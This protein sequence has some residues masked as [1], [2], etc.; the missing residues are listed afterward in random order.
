MLERLLPALYRDPAA[1]PVRDHLGRRALRPLLDLVLTA[2][3]PPRNVVALVGLLGSSDAVPALARIASA[4]GRP[5]ANVLATAPSVVPASGAMLEARA[6]ALIALGRLGDPRSLPALEEAAT[7]GAPTLRAPAVWALGRLADPRVSP[8][9]ERALGDAHPDIQALACLGLGRHAN[10]RSVALLARLS[11]DAARPRELRL[12]ATLALGRAGGPQAAGE[13]LSILDRGDPELSRAAAMALA[14]TRDPRAVPALL[15]HALL[16]A[17]FALASP[18]APL[19]ALASWQDGTSP[20][21]EARSIGASDLSIPA[22]LEA[23]LETAPASDLTPVLRA[24]TKEID[25]ILSHA[26]GRGGSARRAALEALDARG[27][28]P[29]VGPLA[30]IDNGQLDPE[31]A[32]AAREIAWPLADG[33]ASALDD[34]DHRIRALALRVLAKL[35]D[36]R[37]TPARLAGAVADGTPALADA[38]VLSAQILVRTRPELAAPIAGAVAPLLS[39]GGPAVSWSCRLAAVQLLASLGPPGLPPLDRAI[40]DPNALVRAAALEAVDRAR[41]SRPRPPPG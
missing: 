1:D 18:E 9:L 11:A 20:P 40:N 21:D 17:E 15:A 6:A 31:A 37:L 23:L 29:A 19:A 12:A 7:A 33:I 4:S 41:P 35:G 26:L 24:H 32:A 30:P 10:A 27:D 3:V 28:G 38:A 13:L 16:P 8:L 25:A 22:M 5:P 2:D 39:A 34:P 14:W 36:E